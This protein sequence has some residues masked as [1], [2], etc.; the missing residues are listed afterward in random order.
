MIRP[1]AIEVPLANQPLRVE[2]Y[3]TFDD[4]PSPA[5][6]GSR[7]YR[8]GSGGVFALTLGPPTTST[9]GPIRRQGRA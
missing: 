5:D 2:F 6:P 1:H 4:V 8:D 3:A 7:Y 9:A